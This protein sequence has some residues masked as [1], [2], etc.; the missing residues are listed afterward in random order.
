MPQ[1]IVERIHGWAP[2][3]VTRAHY[4]D[5]QMALKEV[6]RDVLKR[7]KGASTKVLQDLLFHR[8]LLV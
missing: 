6:L 3:S 5:E 1:P 8:F 2:R 7:H 4:L